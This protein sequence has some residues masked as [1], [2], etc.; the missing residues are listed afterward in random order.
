[1]SLI[2]DPEQHDCTGE[3][4]EIPEDY[5]D[6]KDNDGPYREDDIREWSSGSESVRRGSDDVS[7][8]FGTSG[9]GHHPA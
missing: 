6:Y 4:L 3:V 9:T 8:V 1:M 5:Y 7:R 2:E